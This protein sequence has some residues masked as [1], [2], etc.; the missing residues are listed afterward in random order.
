MPKSKV[1]LTAGGAGESPSGNRRRSRKSAP[2]S[3][4]G[5]RGKPA[6]PT[7]T[8]RLIES[9]SD[10]AKALEL[11]YWSQER[12]LCDIMRAVIAMPPH[13]RGALAWFLAL[14]RTP[15]QISAAVDVTGNLNLSSADVRDALKIV[16]ETNPE[17]A[18]L[19]SQH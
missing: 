13:T 10:P 8:Q 2:G 7:I 4:S 5:S 17:L 9:I 16:L 6:K 3:A 1:A 12:D 11:Y 14:A 18:G 19:G 15:E